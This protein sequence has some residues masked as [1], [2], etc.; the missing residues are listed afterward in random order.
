MRDDE[1]VPLIVGFWVGDDSVDERAEV[2]VRVPPTS[3]VQ[4]T[5]SDGDSVML[6]I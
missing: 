6:G 2:A 1:L 4:L 3:T 5:V